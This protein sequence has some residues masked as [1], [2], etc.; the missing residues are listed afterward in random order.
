[1]GHGITNIKESEKLLARDRLYCVQFRYTESDFL[2]K[3]HTL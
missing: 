1:M 3:H 2:A